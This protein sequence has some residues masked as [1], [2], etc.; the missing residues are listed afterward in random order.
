[1]SDAGDIAS[2]LKGTV[3]SGSMVGN[4]QKVAAEL[5]QVVDL[6]VAGEEPPISPSV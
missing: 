3:T 2:P 6:A 4:G 1:M 5:E